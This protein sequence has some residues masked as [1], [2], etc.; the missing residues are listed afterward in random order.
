M[1]EKFDFSILDDPEFKEDSV[2]EELISPLL[3]ELGYDVI[4]NPKI[5]R[6][7]SLTH[8]FVYIGS[9]KYEVKIIPDYLLTINDDYRWILDAKSPKE[10]IRSG[11]NPEQAFS[12]AIH[13]EI[14]AKRYALCNGKELSV[15]DINRIKPLLIFDMKKINTDFESI[16]KLLSPLAFTNPYIFDFKPD[17]GLY[18]KK[19]FHNPAM[20]HHFVTVGLR[21]IAKIEDNLYSI[22][23]AGDFG[24]EEYAISFDFDKNRYNQLL[25]ILPNEQSK[26]ISEALAKQPFQI[27]TGTD[28]PVVSIEA[29][30]SD[31]VHSNS[32]EDYCPFIVEKFY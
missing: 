23:V 7:K 16:E 13:P 28:Y 15:F 21:H 26:I 32:D 3:K 5:T 18:I 8:P 27:R 11:K 24:D 2:R 4:K 9:K 29:K 30:L 25:N 1:L 20:I 17:L 31:I 22:T 10:N 14:R 12:Y 19:I 6:S